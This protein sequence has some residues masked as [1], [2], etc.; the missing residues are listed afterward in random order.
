MILWLWKFYNTYNLITVLFQFSRK[1]I[2]KVLW[3]TVKRHYKTSK[4]LVFYNNIPVGFI[5]FCVS[6]ILYILLI[7][8][9]Y[10]P[11]W[12]WSYGSW[13]DNHIFNQCLSQLTLR[14]R[15][16]LRRGVLDTTLCDKVCVWLATGRWFSPGTPVS[17]T[18][19][20]DHPDIAEI[21][22]KVVFN[23]INQTNPVHYGNKWH[24]SSKVFER[25][26]EHETT[27]RPA[28]CITLQQFKYKGGKS[29]KKS[30]FPIV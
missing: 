15:I 24:S 11:S 7:S 10:R 22:L 27:I 9:I 4:C 12:S 23:T 6:F 25:F 21:L 18:N 28:I 5:A 8:Y 13:I 29:E 1:Y 30:Y 2:E 17:S 16:P 26:P 14:V 20:T 19:K 3:D